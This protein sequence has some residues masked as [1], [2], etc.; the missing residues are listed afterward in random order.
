MPLPS[1]TGLVQFWARAFSL[2]LSATRRVWLNFQGRSDRSLLLFVRT[3][4]QPT[5]MHERLWCQLGSGQTTTQRPVALLST[6]STV[7]SPFLSSF[8]PTNKGP[9]TLRLTSF[10]LNPTACIWPGAFDPKATCLPIEIAFFWPVLV[11]E[12][13]VHGSLPVP[14]TTFSHHRTCFVWSLQGWPRQWHE[15]WGS[16]LLGLAVVHH[17]DVQGLNSLESSN[18][19]NPHNL[20][21]TIFQ[22]LCSVD[23]C[24]TPSIKCCFQDLNERCI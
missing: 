23:S 8:F 19:T 4:L 7:T 15:W 12:T 2:P 20:Y 5:T 3:V 24:C 17:F 18:R 11:T 14:P 16:S 22:V 21:P 1:L 6:P 13:P 9:H 10:R